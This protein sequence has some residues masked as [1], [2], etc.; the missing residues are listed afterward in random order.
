ML[1]VRKLPKVAPEQLQQEC[2]PLFVSV[3]GHC[4]HCTG[5]GVTKDWF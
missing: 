3:L 5:K 1:G 2:Q 4:R